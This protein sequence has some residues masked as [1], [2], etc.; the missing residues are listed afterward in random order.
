[1]KQVRH[2]ATII[3]ATCL[4]IFALQNVAMVE[5]QFLFWSFHAHRIVIIGGSCLIG[6]AIGWLLKTQ[7]LKHK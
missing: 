4:V 3:M 5:V 6:C 7:T 2:W 1:M